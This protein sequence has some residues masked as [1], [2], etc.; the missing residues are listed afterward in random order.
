MLSKLLVWASWAKFHREDSL[1]VKGIIMLLVVWP[2]VLGF[3]CVRTT[4]DFAVFLDAL[5]EGRRG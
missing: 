1:K 3:L 4:M 5:S 2:P